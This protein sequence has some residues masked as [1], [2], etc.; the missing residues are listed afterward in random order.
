[1]EKK[2]IVEIS[3]IKEIMGILNEGTPFSRVG[4]GKAL[5]KQT[6]EELIAFAKENLENYVKGTKQTVDQAYDDLIKRLKQA[7]NE[8]A[9]FDDIIKTFFKQ[10]Q[11]EQFT[12]A[13]QLVARNAPQEFAELSLNAMFSPKQCELF[14]KVLDSKGV[15]SE[16]IQQQIN[17]IKTTIDYYKKSED[18]VIKD[19]AN[20]VENGTLKELEEKLDA[21]MKGVDYTPGAKKVLTNDELPP[22]DLQNLLVILGSPKD[23]AWRQFGP[24]PTRMSGW[25]FHVYG[26]DLYDS[27]YIF[28]QLEP[29]VNNWNATAKVGVNVNFQP[30]SVQFGKKG[31]TIYIPPNVIKNGQVEQMLG[32]IKSAMFGYKKKGTIS[33]DKSLTD[34]ITYR[35]EL[36]DEI[37]AAEGINMDQY[38]QM[39]QANEEGA[40]Y[41]PE[42]V[43]DLF[44]IKPVKAATNTT[45]LF[46]GKRI[47]N[48]TL[49]SSPESIDFSKMTQI[50]NMDQLNKQIAIALETG[51]WNSIPRGGFEGFGI[52][53][54]DY[55]GAG[56]R[57]F[58]FN[59]LIEKGA[60]INEVDSAIGR[61]SVS[62]VE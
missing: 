32:D 60:K 23:K 34:N 33:G 2:L 4:F 59:Q 27:A 18:A 30:G 11:D 29:V 36:N 48:R 15:T 37:P 44:D 24:E 41:K 28:Q 20:S 19:M 58:M 25:K 21:K 57:G 50:T 26:E 6:D 35:Y 13:F 49:I 12:Y 52:S 10:M 5:L 55:N 43:T 9:S 51:N 3:R 46:S 61:W 62:F 56:F 17:F 22:Q 42:N 7:G 53:A 8:E 16:Q 40:T 31:A 54:S 47:S 45:N 1:M 14:Q 38:R 39:Y